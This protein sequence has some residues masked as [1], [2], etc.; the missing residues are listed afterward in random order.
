MLLCDYLLQRKDVEDRR[1]RKSYF[2]FSIS[3]VSR[4][5]FSTISSQNRALNQ[6]IPISRPSVE[7][8]AFS[9]LFRIFLRADSE[10][11]RCEGRSKLLKANEEIVRRVSPSHLNPSKSRFGFKHQCVSK[12]TGIARESAEPENQKKEKSLA[13]SE[14]RRGQERPGQQMSTRVPSFSGAGG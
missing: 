14:D 5:F 12:C 4:Y 8:R 3:R 11:L 10:T 13:P 6:I 2:A 7:Y 9:A 1:M